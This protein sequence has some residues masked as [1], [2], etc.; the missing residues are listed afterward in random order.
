MRFVATLP[1]RG[2][3]LL[4]CAL[5]RFQTG[6]TDDEWSSSQILA[7]FST[8]QVFGSRLPGVLTGHVGTLAVYLK[9][10]PRVKQDA[11]IEQVRG[12]V[13]GMLGCDDMHSTHG[14]LSC[15]QL[16]PAL[17]LALPHVGSYNPVI[18]DEL[19]R[20]LVD[21]LGHTRRVGCVEVLIRCLCALAHKVRVACGG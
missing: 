17:T 16:V 10:D 8:L 13:V 20:D 2:E 12:H 19:E 4:M 14:F 7:C 3:S 9:G 11:L 1:A 15:P 5:P 18:L 6:T 21:N